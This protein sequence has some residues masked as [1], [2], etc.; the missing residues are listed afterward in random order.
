M[1]PP[2]SPNWGDFVMISFFLGS[3]LAVFD[4][5]NP[6]ELNLLSPIADW[7]SMFR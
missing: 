5:R 2:D 7:F 4:S 6:K 3:L 1:F